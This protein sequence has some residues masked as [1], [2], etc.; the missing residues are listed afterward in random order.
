M[1]TVQLG[2]YSQ[3]CGLLHHEQR[4]PQHAEIW[5][6]YTWIYSALTLALTLK[7]ALVGWR[8]VYSS[9]RSVQ[10]NCNT[11]IMLVAKRSN[12]TLLERRTNSRIKY[13]LAGLQAAYQPEDN[14]TILYQLEPLGTATGVLPGI[15]TDE[16]GEVHWENFRIV[17]GSEFGRHLF[18]FS[19]GMAMGIESQSISTRD[20]LIWRRAA[21][22][23]RYSNCVWTMGFRTF[24]EG[25]SGERSVQA[26][27]SLSMA[28]TTEVSSGE[29]R[30]RHPRGERNFP[31]T[32][33]RSTFTCGRCTRITVIKGR[34]IRILAI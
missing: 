1:L 9:L 10:A 3:R 31:S 13:H 11:M 7:M 29:T 22:H 27:T 18:S 20:N 2:R 33:H 4:S 19:A 12:E 34:G 25:I 23:C 32:K 5:R 26:P 17:T 28:M 6:S 24:N 30:K 14:H 8:G 16:N 15:I 21:L